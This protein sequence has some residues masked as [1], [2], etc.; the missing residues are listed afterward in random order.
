MKLNLSFAVTA[1]AALLT[2]VSC[3]VDERVP[4]PP[5]ED[6]SV[7][8]VIS[9][10]EALASL[11]A[12]LVDI[13]GHTKSGAP[14]Y[15]PESL[16]VFGGAVTKSSEGALP[17]TSVYI[18]NFTDESGF[19][20]LA[21]QRAMSTPVF[22]VTEAGTLTSEDL[23]QALQRLDEASEST[24]A[25]SSKD[26]E[27]VSM[28]LAASIVNQM[29]EN[30]DPSGPDGNE[31][32]TDDEDTSD[33]NGD[34]G[35]PFGSGGGGGGVSYETA[36]KVG[37]LLETKW[38]QWSPFNDFREDID[39]APAGC[40]P[41]A[42]GQILAYNEYGTA[43]GRSFDWDMLKSIYHYSDLYAD[44]SDAAQKHASD[45]MQFLGLK[46]NCNVTYDPDG[47]G[48]YAD[49]A[50]RTF[51][52]F[53]YSGVSKRYGFESGDVEKVL[54]QLE[55]QLPVYVDGC[56]KSYNDNAKKY[57]NSGHAW[58]ID[59]VIVKHYV[60]PATGQVLDAKN[61]FHINWGWKGDCDGYYDE[62]VFD[63]TDRSNIENGFDSGSSLQKAYYTWNYRVVLY[64]L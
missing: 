11:D 20:V 15:D 18:V 43:G 56:G 40:V 26:S 14:S 44:I 31:P 32:D 47:S 2:A 55:K 51:K 49:G 17:D 38:T 21:A 58:V 34:D 46:E 12:L 54:E 6:L 27:F 8:T 22:C 3:S 7:S 50:K 33:E 37:P 62:G 9:P 45:F 63:T 60:R 41:I 10:D 29:S 57:E 1:L 39:K 52:N 35:D 61:I 48:A 4:I 13:Y 64:N 59:G 53:G 30:G 36:W 19:A 24:S 25:R 23:Y 5:D 42:V 16:S 28:M